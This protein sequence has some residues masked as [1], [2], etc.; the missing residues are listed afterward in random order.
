MHSL[1][2]L[3]AREIRRN[4]GRGAPMGRKLPMESRRRGEKPARRDAVDHQ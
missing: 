4:I 3:T 2:P 1:C